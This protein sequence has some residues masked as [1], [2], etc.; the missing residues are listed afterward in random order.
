MK[1]KDLSKWITFKGNKQGKF[2]QDLL[3]SKYSSILCHYPTLDS[4]QSI[5]PI[6]ADEQNEIMAKQQSHTCVLEGF[7]NTSG[8]RW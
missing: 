5:Q 3:Y 2:I 1:L 7:F 6:E 8:A 4:I